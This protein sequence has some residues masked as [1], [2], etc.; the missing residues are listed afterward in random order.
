MTVAE[1]SALAVSP[2]CLVLGCD[3]SG[4]STG[5]EW[6]GVLTGLAW[7]GASE[8]ATSTVPIIDDAMTASLDREL[9][10]HVESAGPLH[11]LLSWQRATCARY[12]L[13]GSS[14]PAPAAPYRWAT[15]V[16]T[17]SA[18]AVRTG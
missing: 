16:A 2:W 9:I 1:L 10:R 15:Y 3:G 11:G 6:T 13:P 17:R 18:R 7:A 4:A 14:S 5:G 12:R 8:I